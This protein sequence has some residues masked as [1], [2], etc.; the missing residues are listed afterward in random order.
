MD[1]HAGARAISA[2]VE[3]ALKLLP[4]RVRKGRGAHDGFRIERLECVVTGHD[5]A[6]LRFQPEHECLGADIPDQILAAGHD[7]RARAG[8]V[9]VE[10]PDCNVCIQRERRVLAVD[11]DA[12]GHVRVIDHDLCAQLARLR[13]DLHRFRFGEVVFG[14]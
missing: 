6:K 12:R 13:D 2:P 7:A 9:L 3:H 4:D 1:G 10:R 14:W 8:D 5:R 11:G